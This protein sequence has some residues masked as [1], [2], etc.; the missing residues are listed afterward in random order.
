MSY[1]SLFF[2]FDSSDDVIDYTADIESSGGEVVSDFCE[3]KLEKVCEVHVE[4]DDIDRFKTS[5]S[6]KPSSHFVVKCKEDE[7]IT[8]F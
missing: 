1:L 7:N 2:D 5:F 8:V 3:I 4:V 6:N